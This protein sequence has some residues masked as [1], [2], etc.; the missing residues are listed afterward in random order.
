VLR[1]GLPARTITEA[2]G[3]DD[4]EE[5]PA[6]LG[7]NLPVELDGDDTMGEGFI[8]QGPK[9]LANTGGIHDD[10]FR[11]PTPGKGFQLTKEGEMVAAGPLPTVKDAVG[12]GLEG[13]EGGQVDGSNG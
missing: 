8:Q 7:L 2:T 1:K 13:G 5:L 10:I 12:G 11:A 4:G 9:T 3:I 6:K